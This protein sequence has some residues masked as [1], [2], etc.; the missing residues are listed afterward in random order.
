MLYFCSE[1]PSNISVILRDIVNTQLCVL[2]FPYNY[3]FLISLRNVINKNVIT[4]NV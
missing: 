4:S 3:F 2:Y 1:A